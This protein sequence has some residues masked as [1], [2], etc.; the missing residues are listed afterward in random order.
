[1]HHPVKHSYTCTPGLCSSMY[2]PVEYTFTWGTDFGQVCT[3]PVRYTYTCRNAKLYPAFKDNLILAS[4]HHHLDVAGTHYISNHTSATSPLITHHH[5]II[6]ASSGRGRHPLHLTLHIGNTQHNITT[7]SSQ[8][9]ASLCSSMYPVKYTYTWRADFGQVCGHCQVYWR[10]DSVKRPLSSVHTPGGQLL[11]EYAAAVSYTYTWRAPVK[12]AY[13]YT[14]QTL[15]KYT[16]R[17]VYVYLEGRLWSI[18]GHVPSVKYTYTWTLLYCTHFP[19]CSSMY[20]PCYVCPCQVYV[21]SAQV[22]PLSTLCTSFSFPTLHLRPAD[23][24]ADPPTQT[25]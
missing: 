13:T 25:V 12:Y 23:N 16:P 4:S 18:S 20:P 15:V 2:P 19:L 22:C 17:Q 1:M 11:V 3:P 5:N 21:Y 10:A 9:H 6:L 14:G 7:T 8:H 24:Q